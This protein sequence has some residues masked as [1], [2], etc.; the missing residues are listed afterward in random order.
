MARDQDPWR[1]AEIGICRFAVN[2]REIY[3][4]TIKAAVP[5]LALVFEQPRFRY[6]RVRLFYRAHRHVQNPVRVLLDFP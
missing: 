4:E 1:A 5:N 2:R 3:D 6:R